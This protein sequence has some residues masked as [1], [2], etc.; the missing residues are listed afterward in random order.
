MRGSNWLIATVG[1]CFL[2]G[3]GVMLLD[4]LYAKP[5]KKDAA[6]AAK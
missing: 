6:A 2:I 1:V 4:H 3:G 5:E